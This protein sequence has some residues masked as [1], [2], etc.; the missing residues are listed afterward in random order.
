MSDAS[1]A[2]R[3]SAAREGTRGAQL[4]SERQMS[5][6]ISLLDSIFRHFKYVCGLFKWF[7]ARVAAAAVRISVCSFH[8]N[9]D[10]RN[11]MTCHSMVRLFLYFFNT[12]YGY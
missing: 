4:E 8:T 7:S 3:Q 12:I 6:F 10:Y 11:F 2:A 9:F 5:I 1:R